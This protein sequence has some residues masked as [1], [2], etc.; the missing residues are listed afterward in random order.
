[1]NSEYRS[2]SSLPLPTPPL[3]WAEI[4]LAALRSNYRAVKELIEK[5]AKKKIRLIA[6]V[7][8]DAYGHG[9]PACVNALL[10]EGCD[11]FAVA[12]FE[13]AL[14]IRAIC[15]EVGRAASVLI[16]GYTHPDHAQGL[17]KHDLIQALLSKD[18]AYALQNAAAASGITVRTHIA[19][20]SGMNRI[21]IPIR[22][23][24]E[25]FTA[26]AQIKEICAFSHLR[27]EATFS[28]FAAADSPEGA[29]FTA[30]QYERYETLKKQLAEERGVKIPF[31]HLANSAASLSQNTPWL[32]DGTRIGILLYGI[33][34]CS[35]ETKLPLSPVMKLKTRIIHLHSLPAGEP[36]GYG[37][38]FLA[39]TPRRIATLPIGYADGFLRK[40]EGA[41]VT[42]CHDGTDYSATVVGRVCMD[43]CMLD[44]TRI[45]AC[46]GDE[47]IL[48]GNTP[49]ALS[50]LSA[51]A[52]TIDYESLCL[53]SARV[54]RIYTDSK[55]KEF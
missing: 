36:L 31:H 2:Y 14:G 34:P 8:A 49:E 50:R 19:L 32:M 5:R 33:N 26:A 12:S 3:S 48:F 23:A 22:S 54:P 45:P 7:K 25:I 1:M 47:V 9:A 6:V 13:E 21:G 18:Y 24:E 42:V 40:Y 41:R 16:L 28:H 11:F 4:D 38:G 43:Q 27:T 37:C 39:D 51:S 17:A 46:V 10:E 55:K 35:T 53:I 15:D 52:D 30:L 44:V 20:D 29:E